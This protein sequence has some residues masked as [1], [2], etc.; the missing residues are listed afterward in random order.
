MLVLTAA[1]MKKVCT[2]AQAVE[3]CDLALK[4]YSA[5]KA[6]VP[7]RANINVEAYKGQSLYMPGFVGGS[8]ALGVKIVSVY[9]LNIDKGLPSV[10]ATMVTLDAKTG[11][12]SALMDGDWLT[13]LR[14]GAVCGAATRLLAREDAR[15]MLVVGT[16]GQAFTQVEAV[17]TVRS[18]LEKVW[19][20]DIDEARADGFVKKLS[21]ELGHFG[22]VFERAA[23]LDT[24]VAEADVIT[25]VTTSKTP[26]FNGTA[27]KPGC[28]INAVGSYTP[29][30]SE[31]PP[32][33]LLKADLVVIDTPDALQ[34]SGDL[35][36][37]KEVGIFSFDEI[38]TYG[39]LAA[40]GNGR[41]SSEQITIFETV[42]SAVL[43]V[44]TAAVIEAGA[45]EKGLGREIFLA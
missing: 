8:D 9:P 44:V 12:V 21:D 28:H 45:R 37:P 41:R 35:I 24:A 11:M 18:G 5:G 10:P 29:E 40:C 30:M 22:V 31:L 25:T 2:M 27:V 33:V 39:E 14:T 6:E 4:M 1:E 19:V 3:A 42:G 38:K 15:V 13:R 17:L 16:G 36:K 34:E 7:L 32:E 26:V 43:D 20:S 23:D